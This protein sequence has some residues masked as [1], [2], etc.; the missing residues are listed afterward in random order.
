MVHLNRIKFLNHHCNIDINN[1]VNAKGL[2]SA[3]TKT[4]IC[5]F[6]PV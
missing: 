2:L 5:G 6:N 4:Y 1:A 3:G